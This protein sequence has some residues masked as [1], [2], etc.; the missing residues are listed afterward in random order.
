VASLTIN[1]LWYAWL[2]TQLPAGVSAGS[3]PPVAGSSASSAPISDSVST[4]GVLQGTDTGTLNANIAFL[5]N[6]NLPAGMY[7]IDIYAQVSA[8]A[9]PTTNNAAEVRISG[10][11]LAVLLNA[12]VAQNNGGFNPRNPMTLYKRLDGSQNI[13]V[14]FRQNLAAGETQTWNVTIVATRVAL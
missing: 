11:A 7:K 5:S 14:T 10:T 12:V 9:T 2:L 6:A 1:D 3:S 4:T 13:S 8:V